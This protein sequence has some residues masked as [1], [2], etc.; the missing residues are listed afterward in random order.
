MEHMDSGGDSAIG[1]IPVVSASGKPLMPCRVAKALSLLRSGK[2][3]VSPFIPE[4]FS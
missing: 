3:K 1:R 2:A 4:F